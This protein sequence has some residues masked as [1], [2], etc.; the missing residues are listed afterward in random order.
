MR[1][2][3]E[4]CRAHRPSLPASLRNAERE[5][6]LGQLWKAVSEVERVARWGATPSAPTAS[7]RHHPAQG[8]PAPSWSP[9]PVQRPVHRVTPD[10]RV[11]FPAQQ[12]AAPAAPPVAPPPLPWDLAHMFE[13]PTGLGAA[14]SAPYAPAAPAAPA[15]AQPH[16]PAAPRAIPGLCVRP[17]PLAP[18]APSVELLVL[19]NGTKLSCFPRLYI[20]KG[21]HARRISPLAP[22]A[23][24]PA[25]AAPAAA[26]AL[27]EDIL[28]T[29]EP[30]ALPPGVPAPPPSMALRSHMAWLDQRLR[31][32]LEH[33]TSEEIIA[34]LDPLLFD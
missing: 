10:R 31:E 24:A 16:A 11:A 18:A 15:A 25:P 1:P 21:T 8:P 29:A 2:Y 22:A 7:L 12:T 27:R 5:R 19:P 26:A 34:V 33:L 14:P 4:F 6:T 30:R 3:Q 28:A 20:S 13:E 17:R 9:F 32:E 23:S